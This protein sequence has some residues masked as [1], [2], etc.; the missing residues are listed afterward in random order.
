MLVDASD[1]TIRRNSMMT[2]ADMALKV[3][4]IYRE[5]GERFMADE[6]LFRDAFARARF[7]LTH[8]DMGPKANFVGPFVPS[9]D[10]IWQDPVTLGNTN[11]DVDAAKALIATSDL[12]ASD[13]IATAWDTA[14]T[15]RGSDKHGSANGARIRLAPQRDWEGNEPE[16]LAFLNRLPQK[17]VPRSPS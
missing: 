13:M 5:I 14:R 12:N 6:S 2:D 4:P 9:E 17:L 8:R 7:K 10:L 1:P 15:F 3:D 16:R 11:F